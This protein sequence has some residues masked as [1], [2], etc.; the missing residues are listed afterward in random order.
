[1]L[2]FDSETHN[3]EEVNQIGVVAMLVKDGMDIKVLQAG[4]ELYRSRRSL[5]KGKS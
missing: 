4:L 3:V 5:T 2:F 1:M